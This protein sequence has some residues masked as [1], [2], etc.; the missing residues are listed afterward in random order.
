M[1]IV[2]EAGALGRAGAGDE[3]GLA[4][5]PIKYRT[6]NHMSDSKPRVRVPAGSSAFTSDTYANFAANIGYGTQNLSSAA[7]Y[8]YT[9][10][11]RNHFQLEMM[12]RSSW[13]TRQIVD[14]P[15]EDMT[16][17][18]ITIESEMPPDDIDALMQSWQS[19]RI[20]QALQRAAK[21]GRLYGGAIAVIVI[22]GQDMA[23]PLRVESVGLDQFKG[24]LVYDRWMLNPDIEDVVTSFG[25]DHGLPKFY[26]IVTDVKAT[27]NLR[28][29]HSRCIRFD[30]V[31][32]PFWQRIAENLWG[33]SVIEPVYDR[34]IAFDSTTQGVAQLVFK[35]HLRTLSVEN[36]RELIAAGGRSYQAFKEQINL[37]RM[38]QTNEGLT[39]LDA[40]DKFESFQYTFSGLDSVLAQM[41]QQLSG[42]S[43]IP[44]VRLFGQSPSGMNAT[45]ESDFRNYYDMINAQQEAR[46]RQPI[47]TLLKVTH[48]SK[49]GRPLPD[50]FDFSFR[51]LWQMQDPEKATIGSTTTATIV[52]VYEQGLVGRRTVLKELRQQSKISG[53]WSNITDEDIQQA[54]DDLPEPEMGEPD[55]GQASGAD[56]SGLSGGDPPQ[57]GI[58]TPPPAVKPEK[59]PEKADDGAAVASARK[60]P[61]KLVRRVR[62]AIRVKKII[63]LLSHDNEYPLRDFHGMQVVIETPKGTRREGNGWSHVVP[64]DYGYFRGTGSAEGPMEQMDCFLGPDATSNKVFV[65]EQVNPDTH[66]FDEHKVMCGFPDKPTALMNYYAS[67]GDGRGPQRT[68]NVIEMDIDGLRDFLGAWRTSKVVSVNGHH[69]LDSRST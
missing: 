66:D 27:P 48:R 41:G 62:K 33:I 49:F 22:E 21:W 26:T 30:G 28:I 42:S 38:M 61:P 45:G 54:D 9:P 51:S 8:T 55:A 57:P 36:L 20:W 56:P 1:R 65:I 6:A 18:G 63:R 64:V 15:A 13:L 17:A 40:S 14:A 19:W 4:V 69:A 67:F 7:S 43:Q 32:L 11:S 25:P 52:S 50:G 35:A 23:T 68:G 59:P 16:R 39:L 37:I 3:P 31:E 12:Y 47:N 58:E 53:V 2:V 29:H 60:P 5:S 10:L 46:L 24:L 34:M 44:L